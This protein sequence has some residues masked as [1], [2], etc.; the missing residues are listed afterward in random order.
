MSPG[1][2]QNIGPLSTIS[3]TTYAQRNHIT[4]LHIFTLFQKSKTFHQVASRIY[5][6]YS[7]VRRLDSIISR[8]PPRA[9][10][11]NRFTPNDKLCGATACVHKFSLICRI[12]SKICSIFPILWG[13]CGASF[14]SRLGL[15]LM[16]SVVS[17]VGL[18]GTYSCG[19]R[20]SQVT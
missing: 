19:R 8:T 17:D 3:P 12:L 6:S 14:V 4:I 16:T 5:I 11:L 2:L 15:R 1:P 18:F 20:D 9:P 7:T 10:N 13:I